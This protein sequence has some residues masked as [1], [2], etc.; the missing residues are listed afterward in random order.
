[1]HGAQKPALARLQETAAGYLAGKPDSSFREVM[2]AIIDAK[3]A[4]GTTEQIRQ[5]LIRADVETAGRQ[6]PEAAALL[7]EL[8]ASY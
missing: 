8:L 7:A 6:D 2:R 4:G 5:A 1:M 3:D